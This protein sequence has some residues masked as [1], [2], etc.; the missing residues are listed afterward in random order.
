MANKQVRHSFQKAM[1]KDISKS[2]YPNEHYFHGQNIRIVSTNTQSTTAVTNEKGNSLV[3]TIPIPVI[4]Y[5]TKIISYGAK[6]LS[7]TTD[8]INNSY[9]TSGT[10]VLIGHGLVL[11]N[12]ILFTTD[13]S[14]FDCIWKVNDV[15]YDI[16]LLYLRN[17]GFNTANPIQV[18]NNFENETIDKIYWVDGKHQTRFINIHH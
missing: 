18:I 13:N 17:L 1:N 14:G 16:E 3:V 9:G 6:T 7:Y 2:L 10:Q 4:N 11:D 15:T 5:T 8:E 12:F